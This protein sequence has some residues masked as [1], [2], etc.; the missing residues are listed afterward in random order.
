MGNSSSHAERDLHFSGKRLSR[1]R[2]LSTRASSLS[3]CLVRHIFSAGDIFSASIS[4]H[5]SLIALHLSI[6]SGEEKSSLRLSLSGL[7]STIG[8]S[9]AFCGRG[10]CRLSGLA[11]SLKSCFTLHHFS[12]SGIFCPSSSEHFSKAARHFSSHSLE[13]K[14]IGSFLPGILLTPSYTCRQLKILRDDLSL[15]A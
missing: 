11:S 12:F 2:F 1:W 8:S 4:A 10:F 3:S 9:F 7:T 13:K 15:P 6:H 14:S 5:F